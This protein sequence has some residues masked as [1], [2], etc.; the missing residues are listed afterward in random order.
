[1]TKMVVVRVTV[2]TDE[3]QVDG[4]GGGGCCMLTVT[5]SCIVFVGACVWTGPSTVVREMI[6][7]VA[8]S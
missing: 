5:V 4:D 7:F 2:E 8:N 3:L 1:M 6:V